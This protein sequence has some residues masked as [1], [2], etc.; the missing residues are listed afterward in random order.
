MAYATKEQY[1]Q[2]VHVDLASWL[3]K[4]HPGQ[5]KKQSTS[6]LLNKDD[7]VSVK[8]GYQGYT[9]FKKGETGNSVDYL[10]NYLGYDYPS[11]V[12]A[13]CDGI[14]NMSVPVND[15]PPALDMNNVPM[16]IPEAAASY[17]NVF[18]FLTQKRNIPA[19][20]VQELIDKKILY[21][22]QKG[23]NCIFITPAK[24]YY[25]VRGTNTFADARCKERNACHDCCL[26][27][28]GWCTH[29][30]ACSKYRKDP[31]H[32]KGK[33]CGQNRFWFYLNCKKDIPV[34]DIYICEAAI[35]AVSLAVIHRNHGIEIPTAYISIG[36]VSNP[37][38]VERI[39]SIY[40][41]KHII[42]ATDADDAGDSVRTRFAELDTI[43]PATHD[44]NDD[45]KKGAFYGKSK[46]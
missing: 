30:N 23:N 6:V 3:L 7:H 46:C 25:E 11:A 19:D 27:E 15:N 38:T 12:I 18:A 2:A 22:S 43:R 16:T 39:Q 31:F 8:I 29:M 44:W 41:D 17:R 24:N 32:G 26:G 1:D 10:M 28:H 35:D 40:P 34:D 5:V 20:V 13:L 14:V 9:D 37:K 45:L 42:I 4:H 36:G 33:S 21:Q